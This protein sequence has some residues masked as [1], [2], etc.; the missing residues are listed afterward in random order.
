MEIS[1]VAMP[2]HPDAKITS[3][4]SNEGNTMTLE[5]MQAE[6]AKAETKGAAA[7][8]TA[9]AAAVAPYIARLDK[10][11]AKAA[12]PEND[13]GGAV[14]ITPERKAFC[15]YLSLGQTL[16]EADKK[17]L[18]LSDN[19]LGGFLSPPELMAEVIR[20]I[21]VFNPMRALASVRAVSTRSVIYPTR[22]DITAATWHGEGATKTESG[23]TFGQITGQVHEQSTIVR[24]SNTLLQDAP[25]AEAEVRSALSEDFGKS[26]GVAFLNGTGAANNQPEGLMT[27]AAVPLFANG[28]AAN[29]NADALIKMLYS[30]PAMYRNAGTWAMN[31]KTLG[32][33]RTL[34]DG[35]GRFLWQ[36]AF[37]AGQP[38]TILGRPVV[39]LP[40]MPDIAANATPILYGDFAA[41]RV[42]D[43][44]YLSVLSDP[45]SLAANGETRLIATR[46][47]GGFVLQP[48]R[49]LKLKMATTV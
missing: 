21:Q 14:E 24:I 3:T 33:L 49:F 46:R 43:R 32:V 4:K 42:L 1:V 22:D 47:V 16:P 37:V 38:E 26:E 6:L 28:H 15:A 44:A 34:K 25:Q 27:N 12:R 7:V 39:E 20:G 35:D 9:V 40:D 10:I 36:P 5:E 8:E 17:T 13:G 19:P 18:V 2:M 29:L 45:Y 41:Y 11:E 30:M 48:V 23:I 31:G